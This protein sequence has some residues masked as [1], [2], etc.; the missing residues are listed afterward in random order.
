[1]F[2]A[3]LYLIDWFCF[4][5]IIKIQLSMMRQQKQKTLC[6]IEPPGS[7]AS[8]CTVAYLGVCLL[9]DYYCL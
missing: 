5:L 2:L 3:S 9:Q 7:P 1:M 8:Q 6:Q 4:H